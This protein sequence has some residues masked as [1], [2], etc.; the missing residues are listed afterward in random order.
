M[1][2]KERGGKRQGP[3]PICKRGS[4]CFTVYVKDEADQHYWCF[5]C[6]ARGDCFNAMM[7]AWGYS[8]PEAV[9]HLADEYHI[10]LPDPKAAE[11]A[12][13]ASLPGRVAD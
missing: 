10:P 12:R 1:L 7:Q 2:G 8:F 13:L 4:T 5:R 11:K 9:K 3:C 6:G